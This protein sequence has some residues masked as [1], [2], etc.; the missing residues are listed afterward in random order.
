MRFAWS[1][2]IFAAAVSAGGFLLSV[3]FWSQHFGTELMAVWTLCVSIV[4]VRFLEQRPVS[5]LGFGWTIFAARQGIGGL[6]VGGGLVSV[7]MIVTGLLR[8]A[9]FEARSLT[10]L[11][12]F[13]ILG[14]QFVFCVAGAA[15]E[16]LI[17]RG[18]PFQLALERGPTSVAVIGFSLVFALAHLGNPN[19]NAFAIV[20]TFL[21][22]VWFAV[23]YLR[24]RQL[25]LPLALHASWNFALG[26]VW[27]AEVSGQGSSMHILTTHTF[28][29]TWL[30]GGAYGIEAGA[31]CTAA[32]LVGI[33]LVSWM[34]LFQISPD[35]FALLHRVRYAEDYA[36]VHS[37]EPDA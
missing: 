29:P 1:V 3:M 16:E 11:Q 14:T 37:L 28:G 35:Q 10:A 5:T 13:D 31:L 27:G 15:I 36:V 19:V 34:K 2:L 21:A 30:T 17:C 8:Y 32:V 12:A 23:A 6:A 33:A 24:T 26:N 4:M 9:E 25:W 7:V 22:G 20:N 18:Y